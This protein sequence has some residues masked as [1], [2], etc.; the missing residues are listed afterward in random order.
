MGRSLDLILLTHCHYDHVLGEHAVKKLY[1]SAKT[2]CSA[3]AGAIVKR[4][5]ALAFMERMDAGAAKD[6]GVSPAKDFS[7]PTPDVVLEDDG[8][9]RSGDMTIRMIATPG[10]TRCSVSYLFL[11]ENLLA[12][13]E[14]TGAAPLYPEIC[15]SFIVSY[16]QTIEAFNRCEALGAEHLLVPHTGRLSGKGAARFG[17][18]SRQAADNAASFVRG[19]YEKGCRPEEIAEAY[20]QRFYRKDYAVVQP[21][22]AFLVN[23]EVMI[24][25]LIRKWDK[26]SVSAS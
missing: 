7:A 17:K 4:G 13:S 11:E 12:T 19:F 24:D 21:K 25:R 2:V 8:E 16:S 15:P 10:H 1:P 5:S 23:T 6:A 20:Y 18:L 9:I 26:K 22:R 14:T 3:Q